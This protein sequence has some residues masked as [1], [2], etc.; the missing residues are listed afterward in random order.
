MRF[1]LSVVLLSGSF[2]FAACGGGGGGPPP[3][4]SG[5]ITASV[6]VS[7]TA[8][9][10]T[11]VN[12]AG[13]GYKIYYSPTAGFDIASANVV[14]LPYKAGAAPTTTNLTLASG[15]HY[16]KVIAYSTLNPNGSAPSAE[17]AVSVPFGG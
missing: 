12:S 9:R 3:P 13:G 16:V 6:R 15:T 2:L 14:D 5:V 1:Q 7:W 10:E 4:P 17:I 11:A 8:N